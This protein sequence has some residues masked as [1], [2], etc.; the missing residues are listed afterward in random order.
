[1]AKSN[2]FSIV[3]ISF[4]LKNYISR[5]IETFIVPS[6]KSNSNNHY[7]IPEIYMLYLKLKKV[8]L[9]LKSDQ[10]LFQVASVHDHID[11]VRH[12]FS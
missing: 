10:S 2:N 5:I 4:A 11:L 6:L 9:R 12:L 7:H 1:M 8:N 3:D